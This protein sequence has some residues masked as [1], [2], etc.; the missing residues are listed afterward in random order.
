[1]N[2]ASEFTDEDHNRLTEREIE[3]RPSS[4]LFL[5]VHAIEN[6]DQQT[7]MAEILVDALSR[8]EA[9][10]EL[11]DGVKEAIIQA[12]ATIEKRPSFRAPAASTPAQSETRQVLGVPMQSSPEL[13]VVGR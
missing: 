9:W 13:G 10:V 1:M 12:R 7:A 8:D 6:V 11:E 3:I 2:A 4:A 5:M